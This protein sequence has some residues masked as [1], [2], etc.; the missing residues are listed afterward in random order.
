MHV[1]V[2]GLLRAQPLEG[3]NANTSIDV[4]FEHGRPARVEAARIAPA[5]AVRCNMDAHPDQA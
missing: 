5:A 4:G 3:G 2:E 1:A